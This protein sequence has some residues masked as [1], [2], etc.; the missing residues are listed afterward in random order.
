MAIKLKK[1]KQLINFGTFFLGVSLTV[2]GA[3]QL[4]DR[5]FGYGS[6]EN[7][8]EVF[9]QDYQKT[10]EFRWRM[11]SKFSDFLSMATGDEVGWAYGSGGAWYDYGF[12]SYEDYLAA[13]YDGE[14]REAVAGS[15]WGSTDSVVQ[16]ATRE[17]LSEAEASYSEI[18]DEWFELEVQEDEDAGRRLSD[19]MEEK[20]R[21]ELAKAAADRYHEAIREDKNLLYRISCDGKELYSNMEDADW[22]KYGDP[23]PDGYNFLMFYDGVHILAQKDGE[24]LNLYG[25]GYYRGE[26]GQWY[27]P[28]YRNVAVDEELKKA[29]IVML[30][31]KEP[32]DYVYVRYGNDGYSSFGSQLYQVARNTRKNYEQMQSGLICL[33]AGAALLVVSVFFRKDRKVLHAAI[34]RFLGKIWFEPKAL[35]LLFF[36]AVVILPF[37]RY[38][39]YEYTWLYEEMM[40]GGYW[41]SGYTMWEIS[42]DLLRDFASLIAGSPLLLLILVW[43]IYFLVL[44]VRTNGKHFFTGGISRLAKCFETKSLS[45]PFT[46]RMVWRFLLVMLVSAVLIVTEFALV[47]SITG[48]GMLANFVWGNGAAAVL[49]FLIPPAAF[50]AVCVWYLSRTRKQAGELER[51][52]GRVRA[53]HDGDYGESEDLAGCVEL[54]EMAEDLGGIREG[55][56]KAVEERM[57]SERM[58]VELVANVSHDIRTPLTS[59]ISYVQF[60]KQEQ[61]LPDHV[62]DYISILDEKSQRLNNMVQDVF[63]ISKAASDQLPVKLERIDFGKLLRQT[64][65]DMDEQIKK[66]PVTVR[67]VIP[68]HEIAI[69]SDG[70]RMYRVFQNL[71]QNALSYSLEGSRV[72]VELR[73]DASFAV[74]CIRNVSRQELAKDADFTERFVRGDASRTDGGS[75]LGLSIAKSFTEACGGR[76]EVETNA[77]LFVVTVSFVRV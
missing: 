27:V 63:A 4:A 56:E 29:Q 10:E 36:V 9:E 31:A 30:V 35:L 28:G 61:D 75:G 59:I 52:A 2:T 60:L 51:V 1:W 65:A 34:G 21:R 77:D 48:N 50:A 53:I 64:L 42:R 72:F 73:E 5:F 76:F 39:G 40:Y 19:G 15:W 12:A 24:E 62:K 7:P 8:A 16:E 58:K 70:S 55:M 38:A 43:G 17:Y 11:E 22:K 54:K 41:G 44:D 14:V 68:E 3:G 23:L 37:F 33:A 49:L 67:A 13:C 46:K 71:I 74:A 45:L 18:P 6:P 47:V 25:D 26:A 20:E 66:S 57:K 32:A 69:Q